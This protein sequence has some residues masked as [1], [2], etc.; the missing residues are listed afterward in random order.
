[1]G[2]DKQFTFSCLVYCV[3]D[4]V[5]D[6]TLRVHRQRVICTITVVFQEKM[7]KGGCVFFFKCHHHLITQTK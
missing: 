1:M 7:L 6:V 2:T 3:I 5:I 4:V